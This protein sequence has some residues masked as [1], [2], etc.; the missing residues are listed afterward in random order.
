VGWLTPPAI[1]KQRNKRSSQGTS[2]RARA[3]RRPTRAAAS[4]TRRV[5]GTDRRLQQQQQ[6][7]TAGRRLPEL[8]RPRLASKMSRFS[9]TRPLP[10][11]YA[12]AELDCGRAI[13]PPYP[14]VI[15]DISFRLFCACLVVDHDKIDQEPFRR[16]FYI[17]AKEVSEITPE[18]VAN[19]DNGIVRQVCLL[20]SAASAINATET[21][22][23][24]PPTS[25]GSKRESPSAAS[26]INATGMPRLRLLRGFARRA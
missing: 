2:N 4:I 25:A 7:C 16:N 8:H 21:A 17:Q 1:P 15:A 11:K 6:G 14:I 18:E 22:P 5:A 10:L 24:A 9:T 26:A 23:S 12:Q 19:P 20:P 13:S 3:A